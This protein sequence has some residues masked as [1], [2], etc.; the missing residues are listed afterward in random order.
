MLTSC[1]AN[2]LAGLPSIETGLEVRLFVK[3]NAME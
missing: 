3:P 1:A 2:A